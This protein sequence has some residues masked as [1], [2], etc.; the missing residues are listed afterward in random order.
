ML[1][2]CPGKALREVRSGMLN[3]VGRS[4]GADKAWYRCVE[5]TKWKRRMSS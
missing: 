3:G 4:L 5:E 2:I 1:R